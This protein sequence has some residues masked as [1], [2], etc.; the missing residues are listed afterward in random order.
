[1][2]AIEVAERDPRLPFVSPKDQ[3]VLVREVV[4]LNHLTNCM[5]SNAPST[6]D[7]GTPRG[8]VP[9]PGQEIPQLYYDD[10]KG[11][12]VRADVTY[13]RQDFS[14]AHRV[15]GAGRWP[16]Y[17]RF[18]FVLRTR[19]PTPEQAQQLEA[20]VKASP[21]E[22]P[23]RRALQFALQQMTQDAPRVNGAAKGK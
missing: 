18:D 21:F 2:K 7:T 1:M 8:R 12:F 11:I 5:L 14:V 19:R 10:P 15:A 23:P 13:L 16:E 9:I 4:R 3:T 6:S 22:S 20:A 17:Q